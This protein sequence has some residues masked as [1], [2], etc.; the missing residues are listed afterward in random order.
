MPRDTITSLLIEP[1]LLLDQR[2]IQRVTGKASIKMLIES[3]DELFK[4]AMQ[5][6][7]NLKALVLFRKSYDVYTKLPQQNV[8]VQN[9]IQAAIGVS[10]KLVALE[11]YSIAIEFIQNLP[12]EFG[13]RKEIKHNLAEAYW[14]LIIE[15]YNLQQ[16]L[17]EKKLPR[18][19]LREAVQKLLDERKIDE[20]IALK[21]ANKPNDNFLGRVEGCIA[22]ILKIGGERTT[23]ALGLILNCDYQNVNRE[24]ATMES[25]VVALRHIQIVLS[26]EDLNTFRSNSIAI[27]EIAVTRLIIMHDYDTVNVEIRTLIQNILNTDITIGRNILTTL[28]DTFYHH[29]PDETLITRCA[30][31]LKEG[32]SPVGVLLL[33]EVLEVAD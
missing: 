27:A 12:T 6:S 7:D 32:L 24:D 9:L 30:G 31:Y 23:E 13:L 8:D 25:L 22:E 20:A 26:N 33:A 2:E 1:A 28:R 15:E 10:A 17:E 19:E 29:A 11:S 4:A 21:T 16:R 18:D 3:A 5:E 14:G